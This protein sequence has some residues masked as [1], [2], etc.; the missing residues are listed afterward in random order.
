[1]LEIYLIV[2]GTLIFLNGRFRLDLHKYIS[3]WSPSTHALKISISCPLYCGKKNKTTASY[4]Y[5]N[6]SKLQGEGT[7]KIKKCHGSSASLVYHVM[8]FLELVYLCIH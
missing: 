4:I 6:E 7:L 5:G 1:M 3:R 8:N 2:L